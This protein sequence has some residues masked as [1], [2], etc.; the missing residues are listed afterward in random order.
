MYLA[1]SRTSMNALANASVQVAVQMKPRKTPKAMAEWKHGRTL[2]TSDVTSVS[3]AVSG[4]D[5]AWRRQATTSWQTPKTANRSPATPGAALPLLAASKT[6]QRPSKV[7]NA[8]REESAAHTAHFGA[9]R[10]SS[11][12]AKAAAR[13]PTAPVE[14]TASSM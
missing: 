14:A 12:H 13:E 9:L 2:I 4:T 1:T 11:V 3:F 8:D 7:T 5:L 10:E 6:K